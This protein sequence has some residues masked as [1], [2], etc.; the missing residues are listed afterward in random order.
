MGA[1]LQRSTRRLTE[2][3]RKTFNPE[4]INRVDEIIFFRMLDRDAMKKIVGL[5]LGSLRKRVAD[6]GITLEVTDAASDLLADKG[7]DPQYGARP[8]RRVI[9]SHVEDRFS[10]AMLDGIVASGDTALVDVADGEIVI[11]KK[12]AEPEAPVGTED[13]AQSVPQ[14]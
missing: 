5:M 10:E 13:P 1:R 12:Q 11:R 3:M 7:Y 9:Q 14:S 8:L 6:L 4:F 2:E